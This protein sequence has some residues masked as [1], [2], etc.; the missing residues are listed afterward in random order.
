MTELGYRVIKFVR[1]YPRL[2]SSPERL[3]GALLDAFPAELKH[4][5]VEPIPQG[6]KIGF[7][8][9]LRDRL[10]YVRVPL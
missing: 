8:R 2:S 4:V 1:T 5:S 10:E 3:A 6:Y 7:A 9:Q